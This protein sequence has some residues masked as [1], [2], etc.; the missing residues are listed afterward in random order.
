MESY[1]K[2]KKESLAIKKRL[3]E[4]KKEYGENVF[5]DEPKKRMTK[6][7]NQ[8]DPNDRYSHKSVTKS[9]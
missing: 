7:E 1:L 8:I 6:N 9:K 3:M 4:Y 5:L 2:L